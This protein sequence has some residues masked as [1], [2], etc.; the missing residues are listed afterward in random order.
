LLKNEP[1]DDWY[2]F[3]HQVL[4]AMQTGTCAVTKMTPYKLVFGRDP[5]QPLDLIFDRPL[6]RR[7][8]EPEKYVLEMR[9]RLDAAQS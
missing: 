5:A 9:K 6:D 2:K 8:R 4:Y 7:N 3:L 1:A